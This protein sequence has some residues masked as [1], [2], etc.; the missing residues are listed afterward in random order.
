MAVPQ[1]ARRLGDTRLDEVLK[2][3]EGDVGEALLLF[4]MISVGFF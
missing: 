1:I 2:E 3:G 4:F